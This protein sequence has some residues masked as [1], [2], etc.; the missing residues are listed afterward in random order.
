MSDGYQFLF[1][2]PAMSR[3]DAERLKKRRVH[4]KKELYE[5]ELVAL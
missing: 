5:K 2:L 4:M 3:E 1:I